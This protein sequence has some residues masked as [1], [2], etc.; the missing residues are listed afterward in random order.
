MTESAATGDDYF[1]ENP[2]AD[3]APES[4]ADVQSPD[5]VDDIAEEV[6]DEIRLGHVDDEVSHV[7]EERLDGAGISMRPEDVDDLAEDIERDVSS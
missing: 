4:P 2:H 6:R 1:T 3:V 5:T 7:L